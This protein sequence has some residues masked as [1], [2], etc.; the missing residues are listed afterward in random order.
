MKIEEGRVLGTLTAHRY[1]LPYLT[2]G[3]GH[4]TAAG[5]GT[6]AFDSNAVGWVGSLV[7]GVMRVRPSYRLAA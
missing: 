4:P 1:N 5:N 2:E 6:D 7:G 3:C